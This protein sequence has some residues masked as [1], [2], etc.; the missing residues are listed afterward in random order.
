MNREIRMYELITVFVLD[1]PL[2]IPLGGLRQEDRDYKAKK[3][4][5]SSHLLKDRIALSNRLW[6]FSFLPLT[7]YVTLVIG[8]VKWSTSKM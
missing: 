7:I 8:I 2:W 5:H 1:N 3:K 6:T 4:V